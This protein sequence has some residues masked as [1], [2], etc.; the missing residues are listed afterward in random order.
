MLFWLIVV[1]KFCGMKIVLLVY[2]F[3]ILL[4]FDVFSVFLY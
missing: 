3:I 2:S 1:G 4:V